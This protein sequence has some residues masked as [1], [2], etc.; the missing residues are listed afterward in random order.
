M[1]HYCPICYNGSSLRLTKGRT[2]YYEC[3]NCHSLY[4]GVLDQENKI[5][6]QWEV[7]RN[8]KHN[9]IRIERI[10]KACKG[11]PKE[12]VRIL[13]FGAGN[14]YLIRDL[15]EDGYIHVD[16]FDAYNEEYCRLPGK[17]QYHVI[18]CV[19]TAEHFAAPFIEFDVMYK[20]LVNLG[21]ILL[22]TGYLDATREDG[23]DDDMNPYISPEDGHSMIYTHH[24][25]DV[26]MCL[27]GFQPRQ[28][29]G[30]HCLFYQK[31]A[32]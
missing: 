15:K 29:F 18:I 12:E 8:E 10:A 32:R 5:G 14:G 30:R 24:A 25:M 23:I 31:V 13:D 9:H 2:D 27:K 28:K 22:E 1:D 11:I 17:E 6:G 19:E 21:V 20:S 16:G 3:S 7:A 26:L 4:G